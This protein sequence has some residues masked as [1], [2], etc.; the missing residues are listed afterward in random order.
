MVQERFLDSAKAK[1]V[2]Q[3]TFYDIDLSANP[4]PPGARALV[5]TDRDDR[6]HGGETRD[7]DSR[8]PPF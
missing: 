5:V 4:P 3:L 6:D 1:G 7:D 2:F 8:D